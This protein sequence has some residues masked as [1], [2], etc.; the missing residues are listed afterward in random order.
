[1]LQDVTFRIISILCPPAQPFFIAPNAATLQSRAGMSVCG[2][3]MGEF[4]RQLRIK[5]FKLR[6]FFF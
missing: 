2:P 5:V 1:M 4:M 3:L 6:L